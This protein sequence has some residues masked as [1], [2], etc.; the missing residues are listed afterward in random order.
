MRTTVVLLALLASL[1]AC[2]DG[3]D[4]GATEGAGGAES[5]ERATAERA[6][7]AVPL[8][9]RALGATGVEV[10]TQWQSCMAISSK[11]AAIGQLVAPEKDTARQLESVR[12]ALVE[13]GYGDVTKVE[14]HVTMERDGTTF[15]LQQP[16]AAYGPDRWQVSVSSTC[17]SYSGDEQTR[18]DG[19]TPRLLE[20]LVR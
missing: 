14:G 16:G 15:D 13:V 1:T 2:G 4:G 20:G 8:A 11:Y 6:E 19:D 5:V 3:G 9:A 12:T 17:A 7:E 18:I 10:H